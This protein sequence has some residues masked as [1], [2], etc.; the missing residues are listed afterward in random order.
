MVVDPTGAI[1]N[2]SYPAGSGNNNILRVSAG[3]YSLTLSG[4][5][6]AG[7]YMFTWVG[8]GNGVNQVT[9]G[10][11]R[12]MPLSNIG[13]GMQYW[14]TGMEELKSRLGLAP[15]D[16]NFHTFDYEMQVAIHAV[17]GWINRA[18]G[19]HF[20][21][22]TEARTYMPDSIL[23]LGVD[24]IAPGTAAATQVSL[25]YDGDGV[26]E[27]A[28]GAPAPPV[29]TGKFYQLK[30][31]NPSNYQDNYNPNSAG[32]VPRPYNQLQVLMGAGGSPAGE[33]FPFTWIATHYNR[34]Q[35]TATWGWDYVPPEVTQASL[36]LCV[37]LYKSKDTPWGMAGT[38]ETGLVRVQQN[39][40]VFELLR[41]YI[42]AKKWGV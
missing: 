34:V 16:K 25:D 31:G 2:F 22:L 19:R 29:G 8:T 18:C 38:A 32:G 20:Y 6:A 15:G 17:S 3:N 40:F 11:F 21:Q 7:L 37:D 4:I 12:Y 39:P 13:Y 35:V 36:M 28:W 24:D 42:S 27:T 9:P 30:I 1:S 26:F 41:S 10:T 14:Y 33:W 5:M 23:E